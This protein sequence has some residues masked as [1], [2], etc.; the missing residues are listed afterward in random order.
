[1]S[2]VDIDNLYKDQTI[3]LFRECYAMEKIHGTSAHVSWKDGAVHFFSGGVNHDQ[4]VALFD[5][6]DLAR[7]FAAIG[8]TDVIVFGEAYGGK[9]NKMSDTY[10]KELRFV[11]FEVKVGSWWL[12]VPQAEDISKNLGL[13]FV[14]YVRTTTDL[15]ALD[16]QR[17]APSEQAFRNGCALRD[18]PDTFKKREG[19]VLR[20]LVEMRTNNGD[21]VIAKHKRPDFQERKNQPS[22]DASAIAVLSA[23]NAIA[24]EW[25]TEMRLAHVLDHVRADTQKQS[26]TLEDIP[27]IVREMVSDIEREARGEIVESKAARK[28]ISTLAVQMFKRSLAETGT[29]GY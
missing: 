3:L 28:A 8:H 17:D 15:P 6:A 2:Y 24:E 1:M 29:A 19:V 27:L 14:H 25:C 9:C 20:P 22:A 21:R 13:E 5:G 16:E 11:A 7:R 26:L 12:S 23:A 4:F 10:G 18:A